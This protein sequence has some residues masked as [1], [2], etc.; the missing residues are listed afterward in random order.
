MTSPAVKQIAPCSA[1]DN[2]MSI[3]LYHLGHSVI[4]E[5]DFLIDIDTDRWE[6]IVQLIFNYRPGVADFQALA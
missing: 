6:F 5:Q 4:W 3:S 2:H 1:S